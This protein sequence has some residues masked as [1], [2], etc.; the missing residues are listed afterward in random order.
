MNYQNL[1]EAEEDSSGYK[2]GLSIVVVGITI[3]VGVG[4]FSA[5]YYGVGGCWAHPVVG[6]GSLAY[7]DTSFSDGSSLDFSCLDGM[8]VSGPLQ[9]LCKHGQWLPDDLVQ[10][11]EISTSTTP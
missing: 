8:M 10:C 3:I 9:K 11:R 4:I 7:S 1:D 2:I 5:A 6:N